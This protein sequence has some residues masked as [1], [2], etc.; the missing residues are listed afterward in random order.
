MIVWKRF[1]SFVSV[2]LCTLR[3]G[4]R[5]TAARKAPS[6]WRFANTRLVKSDC[7]IRTLLCSKCQ[8]ILKEV[9]SIPKS[10]KPS[11][12]NYSPDQIDRRLIQM[13]TA[14]GRTS[15][16]DLARHVSLS[17][18]RV[19][20]R[21]TRLI[22]EGYI[23]IVGIPNL[24]KLGASQMAM[25]GIRAAANI[26]DIAKRLSEDDQVTFLAI[27]T[28]S[29]DIMVEVVCQNKDSMLQLIQK[30]RN[31]DGVKDTE[32]YMYLKTPKSLYGANPGLLQPPV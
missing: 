7:V 18:T 9:L 3:D 8:K 1:N 4:M 20:I 2:V 28:G 23:H 31:L 27:C 10:A 26:E 24:I 13:L 29:Y 11:N 30:I 12:A 16:S 15:Y 32:T 21:V 19:R 5:E 22:Q 25:I 14:D 6:I 17:E